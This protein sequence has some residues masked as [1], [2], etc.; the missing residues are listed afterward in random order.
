MARKD[1][2]LTPAM[3]WGNLYNT[4]LFLKRKDA[5]TADAKISD[6]LDQEINNAVA[7]GR[8]TLEQYRERLKTNLIYDKRKRAKDKE[9]EGKHE[10]AATFRHLIKLFEVV[11]GMT[12]GKSTT[13]TTDRR[14]RRESTVNLNGVTKKSFWQYTRDELEQ[15]DGDMSF[16]QSV[17][18]GIHSNRSK[19]EK[20]CEE[21]FGPDYDLIMEDAKVY[22]LAMKNS[23]KYGIQCSIPD[24]IYK[25]KMTLKEKI[26]KG[27]A[28]VITPDVIKEL[29]QLYPNLSITEDIEYTTEDAAALE[30]E[31]K[32]AA[33]AEAKRKAE[34]AEAKAK[35]KAEREKLLEEAKAKREAQ[36]KEAEEEALKSAKKAAIL[37]ALRARMNNTAPVPAPAVVYDEEPT[38]FSPDTFAEEV[39][40]ENAKPEIIVPDDTPEMIVWQ[41]A[42]QLRDAIKATG[43]DTI[44]GYELDFDWDADIDDAIAEIVNAYPDNF[45]YVEETDEIIFT[46]DED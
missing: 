5:S 8:G 36:K 46:P 16:Y 35:A 32:A 45:D 22:A 10:E 30:A 1:N 7:V 15:I 12:N 9:K 3:D 2:L 11:L 38:G 37:E 27:I 19:Y 18:E 26:E 23:L 40:K 24:P 31:K 44:H 21:Y 25:S 13:S 4:Y 42:H 41:R 20:A 17:V 29:A 43:T 34:E 28:V 39:D 33:E 6:Y 14:V